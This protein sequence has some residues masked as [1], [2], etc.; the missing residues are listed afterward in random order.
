MHER[1]L[2]AHAAIEGPRIPLSTNMTR[3]CMWLSGP[4]PS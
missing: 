2:D 3:Y 1:I 4:Q